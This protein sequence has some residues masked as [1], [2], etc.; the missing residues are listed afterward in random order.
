M[1]NTAPNE[2]NVRPAEREDGEKKLEGNEG[3][4]D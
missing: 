2:A 3:K 1:N 4:L